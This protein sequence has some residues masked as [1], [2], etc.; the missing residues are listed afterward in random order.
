MHK[1]ADAARIAA[2]EHSPAVPQAFVDSETRA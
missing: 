2:L 1:P